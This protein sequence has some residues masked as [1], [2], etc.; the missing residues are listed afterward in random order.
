MI[1][2]ATLDDKHSWIIAPDAVRAAGHALVRRRLRREQPR[3]ARTRSCCSTASSAIAS[4]CSSARTSIRRSHGHAVHLPVRHLPVPP[5][6]SASTRTRRTTRPTTSIARR[7]RRRTSAAAVLVGYRRRVVDERRSPPARRRLRSRSAA[8]TIRRCPHRRQDGWDISVQARLTIDA[9][10]HRYGVSLGAVRPAA[11]STAR[12]P[13]STTTTTARSPA[14]VL[15]LAAVRGAPAP[16]RAIGSRR[17]PPA[18]P[19]GVHARRRHRSARLLRR[20]VSRRSARVPGRVLG[21]DR[22]VAGS[23]RSAHRVLGHGLR[24]GFTPRRAPTARLSARPGRRASDGWRNDV[25]AGLRDLRQERS[26]CRCSASTS[27][28]ASRARD[29][30]IYFQLGLTDF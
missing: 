14:R 6:S 11:C 18:A 9:R 25:G 19:R 26:C 16:A 15:Q 10:H 13:A 22:E 1:V 4:R 27:V 7:R 23:S 20:S 8:P 12:S 5:R 29:P 17:P 3:R 21:A 2:V 28:T 24:S 30:Q